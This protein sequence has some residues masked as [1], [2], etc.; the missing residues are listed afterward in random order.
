VI[1]DAD[2]EQLGSAMLE[3]NMNGNRKN[4]DSKEPKLDR[5]SVLGLRGCLRC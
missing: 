3:N 5:R 2:P 4:V 1:N